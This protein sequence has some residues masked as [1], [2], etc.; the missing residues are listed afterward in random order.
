MGG[1]FKDAQPVVELPPGE[2]SGGQKGGKFPKFLVC[3]LCTDQVGQAYHSTI[4][5]VE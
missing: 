4:K 2:Y 1:V 5:A 3:I